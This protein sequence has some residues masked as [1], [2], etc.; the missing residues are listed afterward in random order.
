MPLPNLL[1]A[2]K[3]DLHSGQVKRSPAF[4]RSNLNHRRDRWGSEMVPSQVFAKSHPKNI[5]NNAP[6]TAELECVNKFDEMRVAIGILRVERG[7]NHHF[8]PCLRKQLAGID[9]NSYR[10]RFPRFVVGAL[11][12]WVNAPRPKVESISSLRVM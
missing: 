4:C 1:S 8:D 11:Q 3:S 10:N 5:E 7:H 9:H 6:V 2:L 12:N